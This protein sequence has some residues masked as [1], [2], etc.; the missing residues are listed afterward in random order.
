MKPERAERRARELNTMV[1][2]DRKTGYEAG[3][4]PAFADE[5]EPWGVWQTYDGKRVGMAF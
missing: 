5:S 3:P 2:A 1:P 4:V